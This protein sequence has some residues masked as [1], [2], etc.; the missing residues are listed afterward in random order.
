MHSKPTL[1]S[2]E[3]GLEGFDVSLH[4]SGSPGIRFL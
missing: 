4:L 1:R 3:E 2:F